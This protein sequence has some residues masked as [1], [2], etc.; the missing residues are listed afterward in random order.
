MSELSCLKKMDYPGRL[1][2]LGRSPSG[3]E[4]VVAYAV[5]GRSASSQAREIIAVDK[6]FRVQPT[7]ENL[8]KKGRPELL[9]YKAVMFSRGIA[10]SNGRQT[11]DIAGSLLEKDNSIEVLSSA[12]SNWDYEPDSPNFTP[13]IS[14]CILPGGEAALS[15]IKKWEDSSLKNFFQFILSPGKGFLIATYTGEN[16]DPL[17]S[18]NGE[19]LALS[20]SESTPENLVSSI[21]QALAPNGNNPDFRVSC[22]TVYAR[23]NDIN[24]FRFSIIN[25]LEKEG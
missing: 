18:F 19:P 21:Y 22:L 1:I 9:I 7:D 20:I 5:T 13:R 4:A 3:E 8:L 25:R 10:V 23:L 11:E 15:I 2:I 16:I 6:E 14:G 24:N 17:P 12:L